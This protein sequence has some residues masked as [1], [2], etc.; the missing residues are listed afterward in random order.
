MTYSQSTWRNAAAPII[1]RVIRR[2]GTDDMRALRR[3]LREAY[4]WEPLHGHPYK[5]WLDEIRRQLDGVPPPDTRRPAPVAPGQLAFP[6][7]C[8]PPA[9]PAASP[10]T[11]GAS[12]ARPDAPLTEVSPP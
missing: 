11:M 5:T 3:A 4:P 8:E 9:S 12:A 6:T 7:D 2:V 10:A 1:A